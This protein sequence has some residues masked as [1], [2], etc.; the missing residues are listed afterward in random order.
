MRAACWP[1]DWPVVW[2]SV[3][4]RVACGIASCRLSRC[5]PWGD[6]EMRTAL[7]SRARSPACAV[8][9]A[10]IGAATAWPKIMAAPASWIRGASG[11]AAALLARPVARRVPAAAA[12]QR[13]GRH[14]SMRHRPSRQFGQRSMS[15]AATR[16]MNACTCSAITDSVYQTPPQSRSKARWCAVSDRPSS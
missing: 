14:A 15:M 5:S 13:V 1:I 2:R 10:A 16:C 9:V 8:G 12:K 6:F 7:F 4:A 11:R 3:I